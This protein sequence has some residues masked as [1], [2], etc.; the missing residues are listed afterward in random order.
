MYFERAGRGR[1]L[2]SDL[3]L[4]QV[5]VYNDLALWDRAE[6]SI[7]LAETAGDQQTRWE[8]A[9]LYAENRILQ[10]H[11]GQ[12]QTALE[13]LPGD[14]LPPR[15]HLAYY[16]TTGRVQILTSEIDKA[17]VAFEAAY[18]LT[19]SVTELADIPLQLASIADNLG[20]AY[21]TQG[22]R[23]AALRYLKRADAC[24]QATGNTGRRSMTLNN[25][26]TLAMEEG[27]YLDARTA[28]QTGLELARQAGRHREE[29]YLR[30]SIGELAIAEGQLTQAVGH[31]R[32]V[33][34]LAAHMGVADRVEAAAVRAL[35][36]AA[37][38]ADLEGVAHWRQALHAL[39]IARRPDL[40]GRHALAE[41]LLLARRSPSDLTELARL[42][43]QAAAV[44]SWAVFEMY[45]V[46]LPDLLLRV[47]V[48]AH[49]RL[50]ERAAVSSA[51]ARRLVATTQIPAQIRWHITTLGSF[52]FIANGNPCELSP[53]HRALLVRLLDAGEAGLTVERLWEEVWGDTDIRMSA[54]HKALARIREQT[55]LPMAAR[56]GHCSIQ[57]SWDAIGYDA[58]AFE[59]ALAAAKSREELEHAIALYRGDFLPG[60]APSAVLWIDRR[61]SLLQQRY[62]DALEQLA[63]LLEEDEPRQ[64]I[65]H[66]QQIL[67]IDGCREETA[68]QLMRLAARQRNHALVSATYTQLEDALRT[69]GTAPEPSTI[70]LLHATTRTFSLERARSAP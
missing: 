13:Q 69:L 38:L 28:F 7:Q 25:L 18:A 36:A 17:I 64:A 29:A 30:Y 24:W 56:A 53:L 15:L 50:F 65:Q 61:R 19:P 55:G 16:L 43:E 32:D 66:Y 8:A 59:R 46:S 11:I 1:I 39:D 21:A 4:A 49:Q 31:F 5:R 67:Q 2:P 48:S 47:F 23:A 6:L 51:L 52:S 58:W 68:T 57:A 33:Y 45:A 12:A 42:A 60:A 63:H 62:L 41:G 27:H 70:A 14:R 26:G 34:E 9:I 40:R 22:N 20:L 44:D 37:L 54:L 10:G 35:W 3:L